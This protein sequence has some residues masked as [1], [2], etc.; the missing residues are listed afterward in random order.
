MENV[1]WQHE[2]RKT[3]SFSSIDDIDVDSTRPSDASPVP[4]G[5]AVSHSI[6]GSWQIASVSK[7]LKSTVLIVWKRL[8][9]E[10]TWAERMDP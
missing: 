6:H 1:F 5:Y 3:H 2:L 7:F 9:V 10:K 8:L 4:Y